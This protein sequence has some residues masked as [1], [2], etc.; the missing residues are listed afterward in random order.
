MLF[1]RKQFAIWMNGI[2]IRT[3]KTY[4]WNHRILLRN[5]LILNLWRYMLKFKQ[6]F[7]VLNLLLW[8]SLLHQFGKTLDQ[9]LALEG[10][11]FVS[12]EYDTKK[13]FD[14]KFQLS[15]PLE[16]GLSVVSWGGKGGGHF[17]SLRYA[18]IQNLSILL[19]LEP[20][21][22]FLGGG[23]WLSREILVFS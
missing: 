1:W 9:M 11:C 6:D 2:W 14:L 21:E 20:Y 4:C 19:C 10:F 13:Y 5:I 15:L 18:Y 16:I 3:I 23:E 7:R 8:C 12:F 17:L 22:D